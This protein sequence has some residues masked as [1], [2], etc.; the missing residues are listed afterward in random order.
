MFRDIFIEAIHAK[1]KTEIVYFSKKNASNTT[2][3]VAPLDIGPWRDWKWW[4]KDWW[5]EKFWFYD[6]TWTNTNH[7]TPKNEEDIVSLRLLEESYV[8]EEIPLDLDNM[9][10]FIQR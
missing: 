6:F 3:I 5:R 9:E 10:R 8:N 1:K 2:R 7:I 4:Y